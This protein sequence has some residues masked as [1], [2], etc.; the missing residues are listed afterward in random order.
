MSLYI[1]EAEKK[2]IPVILALIKELAHFEKLSNEVFATEEL[3]AHNLFEHQYAKILIAEYNN[4][5]VGQALYFF[6]FSTFLSKP[7]IYLED[8]YIKPDYRGK[9]IGKALLKKIIEIAKE[10]K[11][12]RVEWSVLKWNKSAIDFYLSLGAKPLEDWSIF[13]LKQEHF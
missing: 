4:V 8:I 9:G 10:K 5:P 11:C 13:R 6:N 12:G 1:R 2:D 7:G 3:L